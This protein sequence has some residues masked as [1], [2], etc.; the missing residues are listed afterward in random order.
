MKVICTLDDGKSL[1]GVLHIES[2][3]NDGNRFWV[4][5]NN[6]KLKGD[7]SPD[8]HGCFYSW[9]FKYNEVDD[10]F[11]EYVKSMRPSEPSNDVKENVF[12]TF[13]L[14]QIIS[15][16]SDYPI[17]S[18]FYISKR[19]YEN[20]THY[21]LSEKDGFIKLSGNLKTKRGRQNKSVEI[22][23]VRFLKKVSTDFIPFTDQQIE[24][25]HNKFIAYQKIPNID[26]TYLHGVDILQAYTSDLC[27]GIHSSVLLKNCMMDKTDFLDIYIQN[28]VSVACIK[29]HAGISARC[30]IWRIENVTYY[31]RVYCSQ[32]WFG[33]ILIEKLKQQGF[34]DIHEFKNFIE[35]KSNEYIKIK[36][37]HVDFD[38]YPFIDSFNYLNVQTKE[39]FCTPHFEYLPIGEYRQFNK[40]DGT[41]ETVIKS[42]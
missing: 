9:T 27:D 13:S 32:N 8:M 25:I 38:K 16:L 22:K 30:L 15:C 7:E 28:N 4:C 2:D 18:A 3:P 29:T 37:K 20:Y 11:T 21:D 10:F 19:P 26:I 34:V 17:K 39:L 40:K 33:D 23:F 12:I 35:T 14:S 1:N 41:Y 5:H 42:T 24:E 6:Y 31:D 36:L